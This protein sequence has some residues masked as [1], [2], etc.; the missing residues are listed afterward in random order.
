[1]YRYIYIYICICI[2]IY[3][4]IYTFKFDQY[5]KPDQKPFIIYGDLESLTKL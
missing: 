2:F 1:M 4:Y 3:I 5:M